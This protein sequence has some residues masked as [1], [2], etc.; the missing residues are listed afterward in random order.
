MQAIRDWMAANPG[1]AQDLMNLNKSY[2]FFKE[3]SGEGPLGAQG[4]PLTPEASLAVDHGQMPYGVPVYVDAA[5]EL[6]QLMVTQDTGGAI[7]GA[8]RGDV[9][10]GY[11]KRAEERAGALRQEGRYWLL[12]PKG[13]TP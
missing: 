5:P 11:G 9:F 12:L 2:V 10:F 3:L 6:Q 7:V 13:Q 1:A 4:V 8:V